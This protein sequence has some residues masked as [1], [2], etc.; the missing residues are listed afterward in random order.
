MV[1]KW[2]VLITAAAIVAALFAIAAPLGDSHHGIGKHNHTVAALGNVVFGAFL[3]GVVVLVVLIVVA[4]T[5]YTL[6]SRRTAGTSL[7]D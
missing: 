7:H 2:K 1:I 3:V 5:Q 6:R 4:L